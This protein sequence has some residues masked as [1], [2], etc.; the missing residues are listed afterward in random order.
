MESDWG[1]HCEKASSCTS[2][3]PY[4]RRGNVESCDCCHLERAIA[5]GPSGEVESAGTSSREEEEGEK[6]GNRSSVVGSADDPGVELHHRES[7]Y[8]MR[9]AEETESNVGQ[10]KSRVDCASHEEDHHKEASRSDD[11]IQYDLLLLL[12]GSLSEASE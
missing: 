2:V 10:G 4:G 6:K 12:L 7:G 11:E 3:A 5:V 8:G 1:T 9:R